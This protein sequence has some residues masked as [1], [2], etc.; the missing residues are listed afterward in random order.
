MV[1][2]TY[3]DFADLIMASERIEM[4]SKAGKLPT[5]NDDNHVKKGFHSKKKDQDVNFVQ[6]QL[7]FSP[8]SPT[9]SPRPSAISY[10]SPIPYFP[11]YQVPVWKYPTTPS[12]SN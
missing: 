3:K 11:Q 9:F 1:G 12:L 5:G 7:P 8:R 10:Q 2:A 6:C 4:L